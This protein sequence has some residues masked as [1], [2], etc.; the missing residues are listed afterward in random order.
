MLRNFLTKLH[1]V[2]LSPGHLGNP[3]TPWCCPPTERRLWIFTVPHRCTTARLKKYTS[4]FLSCSPSPYHTTYQNC[5]PW[6]NPMTLKP[7]FNFS[8]AESCLH[9]MSIWSLAFLKNPF[10]VSSSMLS[11]ILMETTYI[12]GT[13]FLTTSIRCPKLR[14]LQQLS[15][16]I[17][18]NV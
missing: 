17:H 9:T 5:P 10:S 18:N 8:S 13:C 6:E 4:S 1:M 14:G 15:P 7:P 3:Y 2:E 16:G 11:P 12:P